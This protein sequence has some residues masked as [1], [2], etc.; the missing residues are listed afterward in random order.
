MPTTVVSNIKC[1]ASVVMELTVENLRKHDN[2]MQLAYPLNEQDIT[3]IDTYTIS[4]PN[5]SW[6]TTTDDEQADVH[7]DNN[8]VILVS[9][10]I[11]MILH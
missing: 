10:A 3:D 4:S 11:L 6:M 7:N 8:S 2:A 9:L 1:N 5:R